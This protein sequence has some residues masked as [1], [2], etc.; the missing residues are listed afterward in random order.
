LATQ[1][2]SPNSAVGERERLLAFSFANADML[3]EIDSGL[4]IR[5]ASGALRSLAGYGEAEAVGAS[6]LDLFPVADRLLIANVLHGLGDNVRLDP[7]AVR[8]QGRLDQPRPATLSGYRMDD[9]APHYFLTL[10][11]ARLSAREQAAAL[12][13]DAETGL[14]EAQDF[15]DSVADRS[16]AARAIDAD[17][18]LTMLQIDELEK[19][20]GRVGASNAALLMTEVGAALRALSIG[21]GSAGRLDADKF[22][23]LHG[24]GIDGGEVQRKLEAIGRSCDPTGQG[25]KIA[26]GSVKLGHTELTPE[27]SSRVVM[28]TIRRFAE[29]GGSGF[30]I[31]SLADGVQQMLGETVAKVGLLKDTVMNQRIDMALQPIVGLGDRA[32]HHYEAL[33][34]PRDGASPADFV[35]FAEQIGMVGDFDLM[36]TQKII[37][38][39]L[40]AHRTGARPQIAVNLSAVSLENDLFVG[41]FRK[42]LEPYGSLRPDLLI[43]VTESTQIRDLARAENVLRQ[44]REDGHLICLDDFGAGAAAFQYI[45][46]LTVN[47]VKIDGAYVRRM[48]GDGRDEAILKAMASLCRDLQ[49]GTIAE[50]IETQAQADRLIA[51]GVGFGQGYL[52]GKPRTDYQFAPPPPAL[53]L[54]RRGT[55]TSWG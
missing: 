11:K 41:A 51:L 38:V 6:F 24:P 30:N 47:F 21:G 18:T 9:G 42:L 40:E 54:R 19:F 53:N 29:A 49:V 16:A 1:T 25:V 45:Q 37:G 22:G 14:L 12:R 33:C 28:Y 4:R 31:S 8:I 46:A 32:V 48:L 3:L 36:V 44:L 13:A 26:G 55:V 34:R 20:K 39:M 52:Y 17:T 43:E 10:S 2:I 35:N 27:D 5:Y 15:A 23:V 50:M 7:V